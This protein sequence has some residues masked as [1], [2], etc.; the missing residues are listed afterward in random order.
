MFSEVEKK[1]KRGREEE[2]NMVLLASRVNIPNCKRALAVHV[3]YFIF[4]ISQLERGRTAGSLN[5]GTAATQLLFIITVGCH[6]PVVG[7]VILAGLSKVH[8]R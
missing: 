3:S 6:R 8:F 7:H 1:K 5:I 2:K 4:F